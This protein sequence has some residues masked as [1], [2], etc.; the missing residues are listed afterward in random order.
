MLADDHDM[1]ASAKQLALLGLQVIPIY[2]QTDGLCHCKA[3]ASCASPG[4]HPRISE[5]Q[6]KATCDFDQIDQWF[7]R[8][9]DS[10]LGGRLG[11]ASGLVDIEYDDDQGRATAEKLLAGIPTLAYQS[12]RSVHRLFRYPIGFDPAKSVL[13]AQGLECRF[14]TD[15]RG[16]QSVLPP[17]IHHTGRRYQWLEGCGPDGTIE[18]APFPDCLL[19]LLQGQDVDSKA[20]ERPASDRGDQ[21]LTF[22]MESDLQSDPG[23]ARGRAMGKALQAGRRISCGARANARDVR[24]GQ[25]VG[26][27]LFTAIRSARG[28]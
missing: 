5:W 27:A 8:W 13:K 19:Q 14:G 20:P 6:R 15:E 12:G 21:G 26:L 23:R 11:P 24:S 7:K 4:K 9:P 1:A 18:V 28:N 25:A 16:A 17:S 10:N 3:G 2:G 22:I